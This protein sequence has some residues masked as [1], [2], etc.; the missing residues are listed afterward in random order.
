MKGIT[1]LSFAMAVLAV[2]AVS[3]M[4]VAMHT[5]IDYYAIPDPAGVYAEGDLVVHSPDAGVVGAFVGGAG[6]DRPL[7]RL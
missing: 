1:H 4:A 7:S 5:G 3:S 2:L 6:F